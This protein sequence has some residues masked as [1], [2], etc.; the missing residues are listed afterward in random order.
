M[1]SGLATSR[2]TALDSLRGICALIVVL[3]HYPI[4]DATIR[5]LPLIANGYLFVDFFFVLSGFV[6]AS[7]YE[8]RL[9]TGREGWSFIVRRFGR[10]WPLH[11]FVLVIFVLAASIKGEVGVDECRSVGAIFTNIALVHGLGMHSCLTWNDPSWSISVEWILYIVFACIALLKVRGW[12]Y[13]VLAAVGI[14]VLAFLAPDGQQSTFD[15]GFFRGLGG[16]FAGCLITR[17]RPREMGT[18]VE[19]AVVAIVVTF[20]CASVLQIFAPIVFSLA[21]Y[22]F[23]GSSGILS[24]IL[25]ALPFRKLGDWSYSIYMIHPI[26]VAVMMQFGLFYTE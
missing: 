16:F 7:V 8:S 23:S 15:F 4:A 1:S 2:F 19:A 14:C 10:L 20:V 12:M 25:N 24:R 18:P 3:F 13:G 17:L 11:C 9:G 22:V 6:I 26:V 5:T 21:V